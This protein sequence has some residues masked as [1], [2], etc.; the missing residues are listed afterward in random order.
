MT[1]PAIVPQ[2]FY[3]YAHY[4]ATTQEIFY[5][6][7]GSGP[8]AWDRKMRSPHWHNL[9]AKHD[10]TV[11]IV[12]DGLQEWAAFELERDLIALHGRKD[13]RQGPLINKTDGGEGGVG[14]IQSELK[15]AQTAAMNADPEVKAAFVERMAKVKATDLWKIRQSTAMQRLHA[16]ED[17]RKKLAEGR[18]QWQTSEA[19][20]ATMAERMARANASPGFREKQLQAVSKKV[21]RDDG[22]VYPSVRDAAR[23]MKVKSHTGISNAARV[24]CT[25]H[26]HHWAY[27]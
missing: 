3:V 7:K 13:L 1:T 2:D 8:R 25:A 15:R 26:G 18:K 19:G 24:G 23:A 20:K 22:I 11:R 27:A 21:V 6:G 5:V 9:V 16:S 10:L 12:Q 17:Y 14:Q 4:K